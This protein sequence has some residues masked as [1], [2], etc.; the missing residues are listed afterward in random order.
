MSAPFCLGATGMSSPAPSLSLLGDA[1]PGE[2]GP[3]ADPFLG[4]V[5]QK[6]LEEMAVSL[7]VAVQGVLRDKYSR[8]RELYKLLSEARNR[9]QRADTPAAYYKRIL[10]L[11]HRVDGSDYD[12]LLPFLQTCDD[13]WPYSE[14]VGPFE[15]AE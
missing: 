15:T 4:V 3:A 1:P 7:D 2:G 8:E 6:N 10:A 14:S 12:P 5:R 9:S 13:L 11:A